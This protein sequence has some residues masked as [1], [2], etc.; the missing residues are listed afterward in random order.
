MLV[1]NYNPTSKLP[2]HSPLSRDT[3]ITFV[4]GGFILPTTSPDIFTPYTA[5]ELRLMFDKQEQE[6]LSQLEILTNYNLITPKAAQATRDQ[7]R[8]LYFQ[9]GYAYQKD[10]LIAHQQSYTLPS[11]ISHQTDTQ[12]TPLPHLTPQP[13]GFTTDIK[14]EEEEEIFL[15]DEPRPPFITQP[16][17]SD[18]NILTISRSA[19]RA[20][21]GYSYTVQMPWHTTPQEITW[22]KNLIESTENI[23]IVDGSRQ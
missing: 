6:A 4:W 12:I 2:N 18:N 17:N 11:L 10:L 3:T 7:Y 19:I 21:T 14:E 9:D 1:D 15:D 5:G 13:L 20:I 16:S 23:V 22:Q 8:A